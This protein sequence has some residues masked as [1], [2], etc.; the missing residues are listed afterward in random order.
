MLLDEDTRM[1]Q[2]TVAKFVDRELIPI[3]NEVLKA[4]VSGDA[5]YGS[6]RGPERAAAQSLEGTRPVGAGC[7]GRARRPGPAGGDDRRR[8]GGDGPLLRQ[9]H[10][11]AGL[12]EPAHAERGRHRGA[13]AAL[14]EALHRRQ[15]DLGHRDLRAGRGRRSCGP[16]DP[17]RP[18]RRAVGDQ[19]PQDLDL[20]RQERG[21]HHRHGA[22]RRRPA[23]RRHHLVHRR[24]GHARFHHRARDPD[25][26]RRA[27]LRDRVRRLPHPGGFRA[28]RGRAGL[29]ADA[30]AP[31]D[32]PAGDGLDLRS[33][34]R[35]ARST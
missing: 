22:R 8:Q 17:R 1:I 29:C 28:R 34:S 12:A 27:H 16:E 30:A 25:G 7:A 3:E 9:L 13:E 5:G 11:A 14:P 26:R 19:R 10:A 23:P 33:A 4:K 31:A 18:R 15:D 32:P 2:E 35:G 24:E 21:L 6:D 20:Q